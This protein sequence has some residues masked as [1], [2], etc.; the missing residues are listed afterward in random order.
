[1]TKTKV[2]DKDHE[3]NNYFGTIKTK[4]NCWIRIRD[5]H[6][7]YGSQIR[8]PGSAEH[9]SNADPDPVWKYCKININNDLHFCDEHF[10]TL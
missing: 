8:I 3:D 5:P 2:D 6:S 1:M 4:L 7:E 10:H 9:G